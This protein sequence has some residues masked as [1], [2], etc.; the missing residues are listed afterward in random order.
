M[1]LIRTGV[2]PT[3]L[4]IHVKSL[5]LVSEEDKRATTNVQ[6]GLVLFFLFSFLSFSYFFTRT[7][8]K[9][10]DSKKKLWR[11]NSEKL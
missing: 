1:Y 6:N 3:I 11:K 8:V 7:A 4:W 5:F 2:Y 9:P 10:L